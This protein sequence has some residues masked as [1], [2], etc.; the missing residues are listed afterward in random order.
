MSDIRGSSLGGLTGFVLGDGGMPSVRRGARGPLLLRAP[1][2]GGLSRG[3]GDDILL[4]P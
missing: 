1:G 3:A 2:T 4:L